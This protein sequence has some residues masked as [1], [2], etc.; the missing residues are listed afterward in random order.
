MKENK[1]LV[2]LH[3][4][5]R[6]PP[7]SR[8]GRLEAGELLREVQEGEAIGF[9]QCRP[10]PSIGHGC[11]ELRVIDGTRSWR[12]IYAIEP[13]AILILEVFAKKTVT[14]PK[15]VSDACRRRL[16]RYRSIKGVD[17]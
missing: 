6:S 5:V 17:G 16:T 9:P 1:P 14:T 2:W 10:M 12:I 3:G 11:H 8:Q 4:E 15:R 13:E 7:F